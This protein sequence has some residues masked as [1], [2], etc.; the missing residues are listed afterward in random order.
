MATKVDKKAKNAVEFW[1]WEDGKPCRIASFHTVGEA[2]ERV[3]LERRAV[4]WRY[5]MRQ[6]NRW[7]N[8]DKARRLMEEQARSFIRKYFLDAKSL[9]R[10]AAPS[11]AVGGRRGALIEVVVPAA[12]HYRW[13]RIMPWEYLLTSAI[14][15][16]GS[17][18]K[19]YIV[20][21]LADPSGPKSGASKS[22][23]GESYAILEAA[24]GIFRKRYVFSREN[25]ILQSMLSSVRR[26]DLHAECG[27]D[28]S[29]ASVAKWLRRTENAPD[30][31]HVTGVDTGLGSEILGHSLPPGAASD[32][33]YLGLENGNPIA[34]DGQ[35]FSKDVFTSYHPQLVCFNLWHSG[36]RVAQ[37]AVDYGANAAIGFENTFDDA[38]A[39]TFFTHFYQGYAQSGGDL[40]LSFCDALT[41]IDPLIRR[42]RGSGVIL[43]SRYSLLHGRL[44]SEGEIPVRIADPQTEI[45]TVRE[46]ISIQV[47]PKSP[48]NYADLHN[49][50][51]LLSECSLGLYGQPNDS[52]VIT[53]VKDIDVQVTLH[54]GNETFPYKTTVSLDANERV[55]DLA[56]KALEETPR[57]SQ[58]GIH[59]P[60]TSGLMRSVDE[61]ILTSVH[62]TVKW[63]DHTLFNRTLPVSLSPIDEWRFEEEQ[64][65]FLPSFV[66]PRDPA[67]PSIIDS[68]QRYLACLTDDPTAGFGGYQ[69]YDPDAKD[70]WHGVDL[71]V[72]AI[73]AAIS[74]D[75]GLSYIN[76]PPSYSENAQRL[77]TPSRVLKEKRGTCIDLALLMAA[78]LEWVE[79][80]PVIFSLVDHAFP[81]YWKNPDAH[82][83]FYNDPEIWGEDIGHDHLEDDPQ[84]ARNRSMPEW[85][86]PE[87][88]YPEIRGY[89]QDVRTATGRITSKAKSLV[90]METVFLT[91]R[92][93]FSAAIEEGRRYFSTLTS[94]TF[95][96]MI[97]V[98]R[99]R[100]AVTPIPLSAIHHS[101]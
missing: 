84:G 94:R 8:H 76:P 40:C 23:F 63:H 101:D 75:F 36:T 67:I 39:E 60:L 5:R 34:I 61:S 88:V 64:Y 48:L 65:P 53:A 92:T 45:D 99:S 78:C 12:E 6:K 42:V 10:L 97:D 56:D 38:V 2:G 54:A 7:V 26:M 69:A 87:S 16:Q 27:R 57:H 19:K 30:I 55:Y 25:L 72:Q 93:G 28:P 66:H 82:E 18:V 58:G 51:S 13:A 81:G 77:R 22:R 95:H 59:V 62:V 91:Q 83:R 31:L 15:S 14:K 90:P 98:T 33:I 32:G 96:S 20:R 1:A 85:F 4:E 35:K 47:E 100:K 43:W 74:L 89:V 50:E 49:R 71:Q 79:I 9:S 44:N 24:P 52:Q 17:G 70:P 46:M 68:A 21:R 11:P 29:L 3:D 86:A 80:Y 73:W 41:A 37:K